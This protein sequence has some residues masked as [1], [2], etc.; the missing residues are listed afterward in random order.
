[1]MYFQSEILLVIEG[2]TQ[3]CDWPDHFKMIIQCLYMIGLTYDFFRQPLR[4]KFPV[5]V[6]MY[7][8]ELTEV[9]R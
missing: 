5:S 3:F 7:T 6:P 9:Q 4:V 8:H 2:V 1:M